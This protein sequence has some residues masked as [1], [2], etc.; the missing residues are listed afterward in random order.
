MVDKSLLLR[1]ELAW[2]CVNERAGVL[3][4]SCRSVWRYVYPELRAAPG[5]LHVRTLPEWQGPVS[6]PRGIWHSLPDFLCRFCTNRW[7]YT[8]TTC[9]LKAFVCVF[10][11][12][13]THIHTVQFLGFH[14]YSQ[15]NS[16]R[17]S[18]T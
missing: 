5:P 11:C 7:L 14:A 1:W 9:D 13:Y 4:S 6:L 16:G 17:L 12:E 3:S 2:R 8:S 15:S 18:G 10:S